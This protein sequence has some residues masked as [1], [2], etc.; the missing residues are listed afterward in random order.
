MV[1]T[2]T[3]EY[4]E[5]AR[6][7]RDYLY[8]FIHV[9]NQDSGPTVGLAC[10]GGTVGSF[11]RNNL[12]A[13][14]NKERKKKSPRSWSLHAGIVKRTQKLGGLRE[15]DQWRVTKRWPNTTM[16]HENE[17]EVDCCGSVGVA[18]MLERPIGFPTETGVRRWPALLVERA[19]GPTYAYV[20]A[21]QDG[22]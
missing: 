15:E 19:R 22:G 17:N 2:N 6:V 5:R 21:E 16:V 11:W 9:R 13:P 14:A 20:T 8:S 7:P 3:R 12:V 18:G 4:M 1:F 10:S